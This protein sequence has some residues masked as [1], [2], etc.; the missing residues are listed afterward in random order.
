MLNSAMKRVKALWDWFWFNDF[1]RETEAEAE[2]DEL[3]LELPD[4]YRPGRTIL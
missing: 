4:N 2:E 3:D 1:V